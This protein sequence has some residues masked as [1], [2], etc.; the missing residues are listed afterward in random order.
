MC[1]GTSGSSPPQRQLC[2]PGEQSHQLPRHDC[3]AERTSRLVLGSFGAVAARAQ[4]LVLQQEAR[5]TP[6][7]RPRV[8]SLTPCAALRTA[9]YPSSAQDGMPPSPPAALRTATYP[10]AAQSQDGMNRLTCP[11]CR[12]WLASWPR[13]GCRGRSCPGWKPASHTRPSNRPETPRQTA[14]RRSWSLSSLGL[15]SAAAGVHLQ[16]PP[17][18]V[19]GRGES[20]PFTNVRGPW[21][22]LRLGQLKIST[23]IM[24]IIQNRYIRQA[25]RKNAI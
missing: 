18:P 21:V 17:S 12:T 3:C 1:M 8:A 6:R 5:G 20:S 4:R 22:P 24:M 25:R 23:H 10:S 9:A 19:P 16:A 2:C 11:P 15:R 13:P 7:C 14:P